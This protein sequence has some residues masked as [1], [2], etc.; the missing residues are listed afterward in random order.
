M[1]SEARNIQ[2]RIEPNDETT[3]RSL[4]NKLQETR[5]EVDEVSRYLRY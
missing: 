3:R 5:I 4:P 1:T 2:I